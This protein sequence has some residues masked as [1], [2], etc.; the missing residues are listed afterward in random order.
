MTMELP[1]EFTEETGQG[2][3]HIYHI[4][5]YTENEDNKEQVCAVTNKRLRA[6]RRRGQSRD[7]ERKTEPRKQNEETYRD[8]PTNN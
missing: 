4:H 2:Q 1:Q 5:I 8:T 7:A 3:V 6:M